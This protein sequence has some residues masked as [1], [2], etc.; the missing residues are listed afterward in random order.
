MPLARAMMPGGL[1]CRTVSAIPR[2]VSDKYR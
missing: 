2:G 1:E